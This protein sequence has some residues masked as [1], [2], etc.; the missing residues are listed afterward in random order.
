MI[1]YMKKIALTTITLAIS[2][3]MSGQQ[4]SK[5]PNNYRN[6]EMLT[7]QR[8]EININE[9]L[10]NKGEWSMEGAEIGKKKYKCSYI[11][12]TDT[13]AGRERGLRTN[14]QESRSQIDIIGSENYMEL[15]SNDRPETWL[16][17]PMNLGD[18]VSG[19]FSGTGPYCERLFLHRF[20]TYLTKADAVGSLTLPGGNTLRNVLRLHTE[21]HI[22]SRV[23]PIS[24]VNS[25]TDA[26]TEDSIVSFIA[27]HGAPLREDIYRWYAEGYRY[28]V[29]EARTLTVKDERTLEQLWRS[30][31]R[32]SHLHNQTRQWNWSDNHLL[33]CNPRC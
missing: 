31:Y 10:T 16:N 21:R 19:C 28:P 30:Y 8:V 13:L 1:G 25:S 3:A 14:F 2:L 12:Q 32:R 18:S 6:D 27:E 20:G 26:F 9:L 22:S 23:A 11:M 15:M 29:L 33:Q 4:V 7:K 17:F 24:S 5:R